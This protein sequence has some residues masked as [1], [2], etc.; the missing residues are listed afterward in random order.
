MILCPTC[1]VAV[2]DR[3]Y[4]EHVKACQANAKVYWAAYHSEKEK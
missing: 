4:Y 3:V 1:R 2:P